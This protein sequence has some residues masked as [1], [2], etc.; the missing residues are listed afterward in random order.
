MLLLVIL[1]IMESPDACGSFLTT[2]L[3]LLIAE[4]SSMTIA[5]YGQSG[6]GKTHLFLGKQDGNVAEV[7]SGQA[8]SI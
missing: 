6:S 7:M 8:L 3:P 1:K 5:A 2:E 4:Q